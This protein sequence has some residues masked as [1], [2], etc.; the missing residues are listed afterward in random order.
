MID[1]IELNCPDDET[2]INEME[3]YVTQAASLQL[4]NGR[5]LVGRTD[6]PDS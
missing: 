1:S 5:R 2:A 3:R 4:W 6:S